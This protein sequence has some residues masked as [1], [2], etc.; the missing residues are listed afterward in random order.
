M[1]VKSESEVAQSCRSTQQKDRVTEPLGH[2]ESQV[3]GILIQNWFQ[4]VGSFSGKS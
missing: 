1:K 3:Q 4:N 2:F